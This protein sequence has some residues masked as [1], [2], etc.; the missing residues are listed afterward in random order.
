LLDDHIRPEKEIAMI[1]TVGN[2]V[3]YP[4]QGPCLVSS[5]IEKIIADV[6]ESFYHLELL[7]DSGGELFVPVDKVQAIGVRLL[8]KKSEIPKLLR[9]LMT[10]TE[11]TKDWKQRARDTFKL[12]SSGS[13]FD[14]AEIVESLTTLSERKSLSIRESWTLAKARKLLVCEISEVMGKTR[15]SAEER[16]DQALNVRKTASVDE[17]LN[18]PLAVNAC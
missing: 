18:P 15:I 10:A 9:Q 4:C 7:D 2:K 5:V 16:V 17:I 13:A 12:F 6:P 1:L 11:V 14:L 3:V 8:L